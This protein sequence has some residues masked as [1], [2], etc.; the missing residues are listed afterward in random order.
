MGFITVRFVVVLCTFPKNH[1]GL[2]TTNITVLCT[3]L[4]TDVIVGLQILRCFAP[5]QETRVIVGLVR[6][7]IIFAEIGCRFLAEVQRTDTNNPI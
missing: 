3:F 6:R 4:D 7:T 5:F 2:F 1:S